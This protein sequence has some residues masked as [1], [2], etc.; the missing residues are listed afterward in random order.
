MA[1]QYRYSRPKFHTALIAAVALTAMVTWLVWM[2]LLAF[3]SRHPGL[4]SAAA[5]TVFF[6]FVSAPSLMRYARDE[7][8]LAVYPT[9]LLDARHG[10]DIVPWEDIREM[11]LRQ[12]ES[13]FELDVHLWRRRQA[14][15]DGKPDFTI[16]LASL[17]AGPSEIVAA[18]ARHARIRGEAGYLPAPAPQAMNGHANGH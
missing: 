3:G 1:S 17:D 15:A 14:L 7:I 9:G 8:V 6:G 16:E 2:L 11:V 4:W 18:I 13:E 10:A 12:S 5:A